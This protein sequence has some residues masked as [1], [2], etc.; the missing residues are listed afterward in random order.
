MA[1]NDIIIMIRNSFTNLIVKGIIL[2]CAGM[3]FNPSDSHA[4]ELDFKDG[5]LTI[6]QIGSS[7]SGEI[8]HVQ[9]GVQ[10]PDSIIIDGV[11]ITYANHKKNGLNVVSDGDTIFKTEVNNSLT[12]SEIKNAGGLT[13]YTNK[14][15]TLS[16][17]DKVWNL[18]FI[19]IPQAVEESSIQDSTAII[20]NNDG[21]TNEAEEQHSFSWLTWLI[22][23]SLITLILLSAY[24]CHSKG[25]FKRLFKKAPKTCEMPHD[26]IKDSNQAG[27]A[28][29]R[30][31]DQN[32]SSSEK[33]NEPENS[34]EVILNRLLPTDVIYTPNE[35]EVLIAQKL[36]LA[37]KAI[38][39]QEGLTIL[40]Y[41]LG[42]PDDTP[43]NMMVEKIKSLDQKES[44]PSK[45]QYRNIREEVS[46]TLITKITER[47]NKTLSSLVEKSKDECNE[48]KDYY[49]DSLL[50]FFKLLSMCV[51]SFSTKQNTNSNNMDFDHLMN[52]SENR[53]K[54]M[55]WAIEQ[56]EDRGFKGLDK[57]KAID[58]VFG[59]VA[60]LLLTASTIQELPSANDIVDTAIL[61]NQLTE[62]QKQV[63]LRRLIDNINGKIIDSS[64]KFDSSISLSDFV[65]KIAEK[66]Q[67]PS[68]HEEAENM[69]RTNNLNAVNELLE[70]NLTDFDKKSLAS[71]FRSVIVK[72]LNKQLKG[73][74]AESYDDA[75][76]K[77]VVAVSNSNAVEDVLK[78]FDASGLSELPQAIREKQATELF[79]SVDKKINELL[80]DKHIGSIQKLVNALIKFAE[81][82]KDNNE[83]IAGALEEK[84]SMRDAEF[85]ASND[86]DVIKLIN[87]Y[88]G[89]VSAKEKGL[90][91]EISDKDQKIANL[92]TSLS[93]KE[94]ENSTLSDKNKVLMSETNYL[95]DSLHFG[96]DKILE[97]CK[98]I[99]N[100]CSDNDE[101]QCVDIEDRLFEEL[102]K[103]IGLFKSFNVGEDVKPA[104][105]RI[106]IQEILIKELSKE[107]S[108]VNTVCRYYAYSRLPF[109]TDTS[110]EYGITFNRKNMSE[111]FNS[112][113][114]LYVQ[115]GINLNIPNL[116]VVGFEEGNFE[117]LTGQTYGD[118]DNLCQNSRNHFDNIDSN[119][120][121]SNVI[122]DVVN[123][124]YTIDGKEGRITSVLTY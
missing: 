81:D 68:T 33:I 62:E 35:K 55:R 67:N 10:L 11:V 42:L 78:Q 87:V 80:P 46:S 49:Y 116:F 104:D 21:V 38:E 70:S 124:G 73:F 27:K 34:I 45:E 75:M 113:E 51:D 110:R 121:P 72:L 71:A 64:A 123:I 30:D 120:K 91:G 102:N 94:N 103:T 43:V 53:R 23:A 47:G 1:C 79:K 98:T 111:L 93:E 56:I 36:S 4:K 19:E 50:R 9:S 29:E 69:V 25:V 6:K 109:M 107:N 114:S 40:R 59:K 18:D 13:L 86:T 101:S 118:L 44:V 52:T 57:N 28:N 26:G 37:N 60:T 32:L 112:I 65:V 12:P 97:N 96:A 122:V 82:A 119:A 95:I 2:A 106:R 89:L 41:A 99:L 117:N 100:P 74:D 3:V 24:I 14:N 92:E 39:A 115:F 15:Y 76:S 20:E 84:I 17:G 16:H 8:F 105:A 108:P 77:L 66:A 48:S 5:E 22:I 88:D 63:L 58:E 85:V 54:M 61:E 7:K 90:N 31:E 83:L